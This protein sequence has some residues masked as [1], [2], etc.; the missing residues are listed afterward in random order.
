[1][2]RTSVLCKNP[3]PQENPA[4]CC[5]LPPSACRG[6]AAGAACP[7]PGARRGAV[8]VPRPGRFPGPGRAGCE[9]CVCCDSAAC[10]HLATSLLPWAAAA[11][12]TAWD[13]GGTPTAPCCVLPCREPCRTKQSAGRCCPASSGG[14]HSLLP[15]SCWS[16]WTLPWIRVSS[17][18]IYPRFNNHLPPEPWSVAQ[19]LGV[20]LWEDLDNAVAW[21]LSFLFFQKIQPVKLSAV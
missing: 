21:G 4:G 10:G 12:A 6:V 14:G 11:A 8:V 9:G 20:L 5:F 15:P 3:L 18:V 17:T 2:S 13:V 1:M 7:F 16:V 19:G